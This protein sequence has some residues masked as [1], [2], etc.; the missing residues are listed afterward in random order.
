MKVT[1]E[2]DYKDFYT[3]SDL[4]RAKEII[5]IEKD[6]LETPKG[7]AEYAV[8]EALKGTD[9]FD[10]DVLEASARTAKNRKAWNC[11]YEG[12][13]DMDVWITATARTSK[14]MIE[15]GAYL[16]DI[17]QSGAA[18]YKNNMYIQYYAKSALK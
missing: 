9:E 1:L 5:K 14:G 3:V 4:E 10:R 8:R 12:S 18:P 6:D 13:Y 7:W 16:S 11:Y 17:W 2:K 15:I